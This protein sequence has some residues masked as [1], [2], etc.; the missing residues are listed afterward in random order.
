[1]E[2]KTFAELKG[3]INLLE[4]ALYNGYRLDKS[5]SSR[6]NPVLKG[7]NGETL[8]LKNTGQ[9]DTARYFNAT[10]GYNT[11]DK[12]NIIDFVKQRIGTVFP[13]EP[14]LSLFGNVN[15]VLHQYLNIPVRSRPLVGY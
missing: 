3:E 8:V 11:A 5:S 6:R 2:N 9:N 1:M 13:S 12:G 10:E 7:G 14:G 4:F 15:K